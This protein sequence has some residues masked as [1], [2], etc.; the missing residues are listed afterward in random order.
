MYKNLIVLIIIQIV[1][2]CKSIIAETKRGQKKIFYLR[3]NNPI[4]IRLAVE[5]FSSDL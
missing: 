4:A 3:T 2:K 5:K 1:R